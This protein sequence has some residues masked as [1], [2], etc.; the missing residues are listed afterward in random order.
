MKDSIQYYSGLHSFKSAVVEPCK[1]S[2]NKEKHTYQ[3]EE[4]LP[5]VSFEGTD[6]REELRNL[7]SYMKP[8][9][10]ERLQKQAEESVAQIAVPDVRQNVVFGEHGKFSASRYFAGFE[11]SAFASYSQTAGVQP[12]VNIYLSMGYSAGNS[13]KDGVHIAIAGVVFAEILQNSGYAVNIY[14]TSAGKRGDD[15]G[16]NV[17]TAKESGDYLDS[18]N[19]ATVASDPR[20]FRHFGFLGIIKNFDNQGKDVPYGYG[21]PIPIKKQRQLLEADGNKVDF[22]FGDCLNMASA[23]SQLTKAVNTLKQQHADTTASF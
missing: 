21:A 15:I 16:L 4:R 23:I 5:S 9:L 10:L 3:L 8:E 12:T 19:V 17:I 2:H 1:R 11:D 7:K 6:S 22:I 20:F 18:D 14:V 13:A